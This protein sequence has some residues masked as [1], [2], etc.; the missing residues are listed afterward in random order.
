VTSASGRFVV[1]GVC[2]NAST[3]VAS[4]LTPAASSSVSTD[5]PVKF[6]P[7]FDHVVTQ[8]MS[9]EYVDGGSAWISSHVQVVGRS[10]RPSMRNV[11]FARSIFGVTSAVRTGQCEPTSYWPGGNRGSRVRDRPRNPR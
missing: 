1:Y 4:G 6:T 7:S 3:C 9:P 10:T 8:W 5:T 11:H 2:E